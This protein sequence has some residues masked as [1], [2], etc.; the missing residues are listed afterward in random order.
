MREEVLGSSSDS[1][2]CERRDPARYRHVD[3]I[4]LAKGQ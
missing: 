3:K 4:Y 1:A 2:D